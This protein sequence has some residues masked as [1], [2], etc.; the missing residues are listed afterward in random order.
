MPSSDGAG[1]VEAL[2][3]RDRVQSLRPSNI[4]RS[5]EVR[6]ACRDAAVVHYATNVP[7]A[8]WQQVLPAMTESVIAGASAANV[9]LVAVDN[10]YMYG[11]SSG[12][13]TEDSPRRASGPKGQLRA[14][15]EE[16]FLAALA[17]G[18]GGVA[19]G[20]GADFHG[21]MPTQPSTYR[22]SCRLCG[23]RLPP[24]SVRWMRL[25]RSPTCRT[26][27]AV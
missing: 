16:T 2:R 12:P 5:D 22:L 7:Y 17:S 10:L 21:P 13:M 4:L 14:R 25:I 27:P 26:L 9:V 20:R 18:R 11:S 3:E 19:I 15:L 6:K 24:G 8:Q 1:V 23:E